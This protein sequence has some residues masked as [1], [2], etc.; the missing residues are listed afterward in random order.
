MI[1][2]LSGI[3]QV[4]RLHL[5]LFLHRRVFFSVLDLSDNQ[6]PPE[7][8]EE[9]VDLLSTL[10]SLAVLRLIGNPIVRT[11][12]FPYRKTLISHCKNLK[13][14]DDRPV[15]D[16]ER[17]L[18][19]AWARGTTREEK[20][21]FEQEERE[22]QRK[23]EEDKQEANAN[24]LNAPSTILHAIYNITSYSFSLRFSSPPHLSPFSY[25]NAHGRCP[26]PAP[27]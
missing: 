25:A 13:Y 8:A 6:L 10:P 22:R 3:I 24:G 9:L 1:Y 14:L 19:E 4:S 20:L 21:R 26:F 16:S 5:L 15:F 23:V 17:L 11:T 2:K 27:Y 18:V 7:E 12:V